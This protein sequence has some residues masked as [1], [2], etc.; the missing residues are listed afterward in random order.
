MPAVRHQLDYVKAPEER[1]WNADAAE[2]RL[3]RWASSDG[4]GEKD[5]IDWSK[6]REG[7]AWYDDNEPENFGSYK[8]PHHDI[9][10]GRFAVVWRGVSA[11]A[12]ALM[13]AR[14]GVHLPPRD[15]DDV[16]AH[17]ARHYREFGRTPPWEQE[18]FNQLKT[19][20]EHRIAKHGYD[21]PEAKEAAYMLAQVIRK[22]P[23]PPLKNPIKSYSFK[24]VSPIPEEALSLRLAKLVAIYQGPSAH[25]GDASNP[26][27]IHDKDEVVRAARTLF[28][29]PLDI[30]HL[31]YPLPLAIW[32]PEIARAYREKWGIDITR[33]VGWV[34]DAEEEDGK[35][36]AIAMIDQQEVYDIL[37]MMQGVSVVE[38]I[39]LENCYV[40]DS[41]HVCEIK[42]AKFIAAALCLEGAPAY[43]ETYV[44][45]ITKNDS[46]IQIISEKPALV[47]VRRRNGI[48]YVSDSGLV[49]PELVNSYLSLRNRLD[50]AD[51]ALT[52]LQNKLMEDIKV[53]E[54]KTLDIEFGKAPPS[55]VLEP[56][57]VEKKKP[58]C[59]H[60]ELVRAL[61]LA[62]TDV[63]AYYVKQ[64]L[65]RVLES[66][67]DCE[68]RR[69]I[70]DMNIPL[71]ARGVVARDA[72]NNLVRRIKL[73]L[74][75][76]SSRLTEAGRKS[77]P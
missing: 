12:A 71:G 7:F 3:R 72:Y 47:A 53:E 9:V 5:K 69:V 20:L 50:K 28:N 10:D 75:E 2:Q 16:R 31:L 65:D 27:N 77:L 13:G 26:I 19:L 48:Q 32:Y 43:P 56:N 18:S 36:E 35:V 51:R 64:T 4:S 57:P 33:P 41:K 34:L 68:H 46:E 22:N 23:R 70:A 15:V 59:S 29:K 73:A 76:T 67:K 11:A 24:W 61:S 44:K 52:V 14:G 8:L 42:G 1:P 54:I 25:S 66:V 37:D 58:R 62:E 74:L 40:Q 55:V 6:Y 21:S 38:I 49:S 39:R 45:P 30:D 60:L 63:P 17:I